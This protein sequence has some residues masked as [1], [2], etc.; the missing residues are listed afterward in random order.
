MAQAR[1][2]RD[3][4]LAELRFSQLLALFLHDELNSFLGKLTADIRSPGLTTRDVT[5]PPQ[6]EAADASFLVGRGRRGEADR[7]CV[8]DEAG[9]G[10]RTRI[11]EECRDMPLGGHFGR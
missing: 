8:P 1:V 7:L 4:G 3:A 11:L 6:P 10:L 9:R 5:P 2:R